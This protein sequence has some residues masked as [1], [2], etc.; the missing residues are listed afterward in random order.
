MTEKIK[1]EFDQQ[2]SNLESIDT[3][4]ICIVAVK[5]AL[6]DKSVQG[7]IF[8]KIDEGHVFLGIHCEFPSILEHINVVFNFRCADGVFCLI[9]PTFA[10]TI[11]IIGQTVTAIRDPYIPRK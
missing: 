11:D 6:Q 5:V 4:D 2:L 9:P 1:N 3:N 8:S 10:A 7:K